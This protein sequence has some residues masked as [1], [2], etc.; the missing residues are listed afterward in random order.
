MGMGMQ[1]AGDEDEMT[2]LRRQT[3]DL[4]A[5][6]AELRES[7]VRERRRQELA[8]AEA[9]L[10]AA[11]KTARRVTHELRNVLSPV[12]G[13]SELLANRS[14][15]EDAALANRLKGSALLAADFLARL[16]EIVRYCETEFGGETMLDLDGA[17]G[18]SRRRG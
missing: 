16:D 1:G 5:E 10:D 3:V 9:R 6:V 13:Y 7:L 12:A 14:R 11:Q 17:T 15:G 2:M 8:L 18:P 4:A